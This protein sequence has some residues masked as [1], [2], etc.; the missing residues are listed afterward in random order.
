MRA[1]SI[2]SFLGRNFK[3]RK[4][5]SRI[6]YQEA[7]EAMKAF[8]N[9]ELELV[10]MIDNVFQ[11][12][13]SISHKCQ[14]KGCGM[15]IR[16][17]YILKSKVTTD[18]VIVGSTCVRVMMGLS[19]EQ[20]KMLEKIESTM[21]D[22]HDMIVWKRANLDV[23]NKLEELKTADLEWFKPFWEEVSFCRLH[24][25]DENFIR[26]LNIER[27]IQ[28]DKESKERKDK[29][30]IRPKTFNRPIQ[31]TPIV[32]TPVVQ[33]ILP[34]SGG[35]NPFE[36]VLNNIVNKV[37]SPV[38]V[39]AAAKAPV[40]STMVVKNDNKVSG[41]DDRAYKM[42][43]DMLGVL[44]TKYPD[45]D[46]LKSLKSQSDS[47]KIMTDKQLR[48][49]KIEIN[50]DYF[51]NN[52]KGR[53]E[54]TKYNDCDARVVEKFTKVVNGKEIRVY[55]MDLVDLTSGRI[56]AMINKYKREFHENL[57]SNGDVELNELWKYF[58]IKHEIIMR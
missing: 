50:R 44:V 7:L 57:K 45:N 4:R 38:V 36:K 26:N 28:K 12:S 15:R 56:N 46:T 25:E 22:F 39:V 24:P 23:W 49:I 17:E 37:P 13:K 20:F 9:S 54:E 32:P 3:L 58:R 2:I 19:K 11:P 27:E 48:R 51:E 6:R 40:A 43:V 29:F 53:P 35:R 33:N 55:S 16:F 18:E 41:V 31:S 47:G 14:L 1:K 5:S 34:V 8:Q 10:R 30:S 21:K 42:L 52:I